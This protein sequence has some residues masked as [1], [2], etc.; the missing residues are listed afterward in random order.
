M[1]IC[2]FCLQEKHSLTDEHVFPAALGGV[3]V[4]KDSVC[5]ECNNGFS[6]FEQ[7]LATELSPIRLLLKI[8]D[9]YGEI[10]QVAATVQTRD[11]EYEG[12]VKSDGTVQPKRIVTEVVADDGRR[13]FI[14]QF[15][16]ERQKQKLRQEA[17]AKGVELIESGPGN[18]EQG[19]VHVGG[20][21]K[22]I[23]SSEGLRATSKI[24]YAALALRA[25]AKLAISESFDEVRAYIRQGIGK[26]TS[27]LFVHEG[28]LGA[29]QQGPHQHSLIL[30]GRHDKSRVDAI[31]RLFGG[32]CY[33]VQLSDHYAGADFF[34]TLV[35]DAS[36]GEA[37]GILQSHLDAEILQIEDVSTSSDTR[38]DD[39]PASGK[40]FCEFLESAIQSKLK[41]ARAEN[42][43]KDP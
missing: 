24:A 32:L 8:P 7:P 5:S 43:A 21:L 41:R 29:V 26:P 3:L 36:R 17:S 30:A 31:V 38:W 23:G 20:D 14:H 18:P 4:L 28:F 12:R 35:Y 9:R 13:E 22:F 40:R 33:F 11:K 6:K 16:T 39:L 1:P 15:L 27:R 19:E 10:P 42:P 34:D 2:I 37:N 25:G